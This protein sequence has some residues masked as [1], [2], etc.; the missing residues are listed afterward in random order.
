MAEVARQIK[1]LGISR[2][3]W[4]WLLIVLAAVAFLAVLG[5]GAFAL[6]ARPNP[7]TFEQLTG[8]FGFPEEAITQRPTVILI[9]RVNSDRIVTVLPGGV[10]TR[11]QSSFYFSSRVRL[12][13]QIEDVN[14][15]RNPDLVVDGVIL[16]NLGGRFSIEPPTPTPAPGK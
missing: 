6:L 13:T 16:Y 4:R 11:V 2:L 12:P 3:T 14:G 9:Q 7:Q 15:D 10:A 1:G 5:M 8:F